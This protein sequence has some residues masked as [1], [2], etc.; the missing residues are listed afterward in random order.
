MARR[1]RFWPYLRVGLLVLA[2]L[3]AG[4]TLYLDIRV[5]HE[6]EG[7]RFALPARIYARPLELHVGLKLPE[8]DVV[9]ELRE[10]G[11]RPTARPDGSGWYVRNGA[12][13][14]IAVR[15][16]VFWDGPQPARRL[17]V[18][19]EAGAVTALA[20]AQGGE[21]ALARLEPLPIGG[22]YPTNNEDRLL[23]R[24][25]DVPK[26]LLKELIAVEDRNYY[27]HWG[28]DPRGIARAV[29]SLGSRHVQGGSTLTQQLV[30]NFFLTPE[31]TIR[32][33]L[34]ELVMAVLL[35]LH[36]GKQE[37]LETYLNEIYLGQDRDRAIHGVG[38][39]AQFYFD[40]PVG[41][42]SLAESALLVGLVRGPAYYDPYRHPQRALERRNLVLRET[43]DEGFISAAQYQAARATGLGLNPRPST[44]TTPYPAFVDLVHR[45]LRHDYDEADLRSEGLR[46]F[47]T[48]DPQAQAAAEHALADRLAAFD[49]QGRFG[50]PGLEGAV[51]M[52]DPQSG[53][54]QALVGGRDPRYQGF[55][56]ALDAERQI[57]SL[58]KPAIYL[59]AL[60]DPSRYTLATPLDDGPFTWK[61]RDAEPWRPENYDKQYHG[62]V[63]LYLALAHSYN[64][65]AARLGTTLGL[66][67]V[68]ATARK[69]GV[70]RELPQYPSALLGAANLSPFE[71]TQMYQTIA[72]GGFRSPL[73]AI[74]DVTTMDGR[75]LKRYPLAVAQ[76][77]PPDPMYLLTAALQDVVRE[78]TA[79]S[80]ANWLPPLGV[81][82]KTGTTN[83]QR[84]AWFAGFTGG[85]VAVVWVGY[86][87]NRPAR[88]LGATAALPVWGEM[89]AALVPEPVAFPQ[90][91]DIEQVTID[92]Q[93]GLVADAACPGALE[94]PFVKGSAP[95]E[96][97]PCAGNAVVDN[98][99]G[100]FQ[101]MFGQ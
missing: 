29:L 36:Y 55:N 43:R 17:R 56:R 88:L 75:P 83:E 3:A 66:E 25:S 7:R 76:V 19:F 94:L 99:K 2:L 98:V 89:M 73:H 12:E 96:R 6:F 72:S 46:I 53:E 51:V 57:G 11:Y 15:P 21:L 65:A 39:A 22:I 10:L 40:K 77:F 91:E 60:E 1:R 92:P 8:D 41:K 34:T 93:T 27:S 58:F 100:F 62:Q 59:T 85:R 45:Q 84:D 14:E 20:D 82:G 81:A 5:R 70:E 47:T 31:R 87:D 80:L 26:A 9:R 44:G 71:V 90:P 13:L 4:Y 69:L 63:P 50:K 67:R 48:L 37:I 49:R 74:R 78:G 54:V 95:Q 86:D 28:F 16:F 68:L 52:A 42:L 64:V 101:R 97:A 18:A 38:L 24:L 30:K 33:K 61:P 23:V 79:K 35:E 32:R